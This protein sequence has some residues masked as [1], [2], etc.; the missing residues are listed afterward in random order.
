MSPFVTSTQPV[1]VGVCLRLYA[2]TSHVVVY[3]NKSAFVTDT[4][5]HAPTPYSTPGRCSTVLLMVSGFNGIRF[6][7]LISI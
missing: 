3:L 1:P 4:F 7:I 5:L 6:H 2:L